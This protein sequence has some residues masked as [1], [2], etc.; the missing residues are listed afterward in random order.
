MVAVIRP[1]MTTVVCRN[2][3]CPACGVEKTVGR[4]HLGQDVYAGGPLI[5]GGCGGQLQQVAE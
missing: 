4:P 5:C 1:G 2:P 3:G